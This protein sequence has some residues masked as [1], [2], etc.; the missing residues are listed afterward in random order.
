MQAMILAAGEGTRMRPLTAKTPKPMLP[1][2]GAPILEHTIQAAIDA[3]ATELIL[4]VGY[5]EDAIRDRFGNSYNGT[6][7]RYAV[8]ETQQGT[9]HAVRAGATELEDSP[10]AVLNGDVLYDRASLE[11]VFDSGP[12]VGSYQVENPSAF[13]VLELDSE[14]QFV[15]DVHEKPDDPQSNLINAGAY[16]FP[17]EA[18]EWLD[19]P[20]SDRGELELTDVLSRTC[21]EFDVTP[22]PFE[23]WLDIG[24]PWELLEANEWKLT[25][26]ADLQ[27][28]TV[29]PDAEIRGPV[30]I[31]EGAEIRSGV[32]IEGP[33]LIK[34]GT[35]VGP[36]AYIRGATQLSEDVHIGHGVEVK[37]S[38]L[39]E[40]ATIGHLSYVGDSLLG[41]DVNFG[42][43]T[44]VANLR[45][46]DK[47]VLIDVKGE[48]RST[49]RRKF[50]CVCGPAVKTGI[51]TSLNAGVK[52][53]S[54]ATT[55]PGERVL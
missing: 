50:G 16:V 7:L 36:N 55:L 2:A 47:P 39:M 14:G 6:P 54:G 45:H 30:R 18:K 31:E 22:V 20:Q 9:A 25:E 35:T 33:V 32:V 53:D 52:L 38:V 34:E 23:R 19:V 15:V 24:H 10:F 40:G 49:G 4:V 3:G 12:S 43:G 5:E 44:T 28:G 48:K 1:V 29:H 42:A 46:D 51:N 13:G 26:I 17:A 11:Q 37:N 41:Q 21:A 27:S 8:Q